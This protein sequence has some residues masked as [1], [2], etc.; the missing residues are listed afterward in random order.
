MYLHNLAQRGDNAIH[1]AARKGKVALIEQM[2]KAGVDVEQ[3][4]PVC[5]YNDDM[6]FLNCLK[7]FICKSSI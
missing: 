2:V 7:T 4:N 5:Q 6:T 1:L 3:K